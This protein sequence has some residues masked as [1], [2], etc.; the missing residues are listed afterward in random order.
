M[1]NLQI[2][3]I[4]IILSAF[5]IFSLRILSISLVEVTQPTKEIL[6]IR[7]GKIQNA[8]KSIEIY[9]ICIFFFFC[10][11]LL[12]QSSCTPIFVSI[13]ALWACHGPYKLYRLKTQC[14]RLLLPATPQCF[15]SFPFSRKSLPFWSGIWS[16]NN[17]CQP[18]SGS[19]LLVL[20]KLLV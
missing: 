3:Y 11:E 13:G 12:V 18:S 17:F 10:R 7:K 1:K 8:D 9:N 2:L 19:K 16:G 14:L 5:C 6:R 4:S 15:I 20:K